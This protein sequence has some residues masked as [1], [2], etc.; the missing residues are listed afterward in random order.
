MGNELAGTVVTGVIQLT[1]SNTRAFVIAS[2]VDWQE[3]VRD[4]RDLF[5]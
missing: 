4:K 5:L 3:G 1:S 2:G